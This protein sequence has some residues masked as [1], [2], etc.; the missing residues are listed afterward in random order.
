MQSIDDLL[1][2]DT[3]APYLSCFLESGYDDLTL[4]LTM[5]SDEW[6]EMIDHVE[7]VASERG[8]V[9]RPGHRQMILSRLRAE[10]V[11]RATESKEA[12]RGVASEEAKGPQ[13]ASGIHR[14]TL[15]TSTVPEEASS[16]SAII[17]FDGFSCLNVHWMVC[18]GICVLSLAVSCFILLI[19]STLHQSLPNNQSQ[20]GAWAFLRV[21]MILGWSI[22]GLTCCIGSIVYRRNPESPNCV[23]PACLSDC[24][25]TFSSMSCSLCSCHGFSCGS[26]DCKRP[27]ADSSFCV[28]LRFRFSSFCNSLRCRPR[29]WCSSNRC[30]SCSDCSCP[31]CPSCH[32][33]SCSCDA[34]SAIQSCTCPS[35]ELP[36][37]SM[38]D[39]PVLTC[40]CCPSCHNVR[41]CLHTTYKIMCCQCQIQV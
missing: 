31:S 10:K 37:C 27:S 24:S 34:P 14:K 35:C 8:F 38:P 32:L 7:R 30:P 16:T 21:V 18:L 26:C 39:C 29:D 22:A 5:T 4:I 9:L 20:N 1:N 23:A 2:A 6:D 12:A 25:G 28:E 13:P 36:K 33:L 41:Q 17:L 40:N 19:S 11:H 3:L 15:D